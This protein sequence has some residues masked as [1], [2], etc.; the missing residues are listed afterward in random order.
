MMPAGVAYDNSGV[1]VS[2][3][4]LQNGC[5]VSCSMSVIRPNVVNFLEPSG[6][7]VE[8][9]ASCQSFPPS[10]HHVDPS[11]RNVNAAGS[12]GA[13]YA[14]VVR[15]ADPDPVAYVPVDQNEL[16]SRPLTVFF[17]PCSK[18]PAHEVFTALQA[19]NVG[20][21]SVSCIQR[22]S[23][24]EIVLTFCIAQAKDQLLYLIMW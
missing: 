20:N 13:V 8:S 7:S 6:A 12:S 9:V 2:D 17:N 5:D 15:G 11:G 22:Q 18:V 19:V 23:S 14:D 16:L 4:T 21:Y 3:S 10:G 24:G 1:P